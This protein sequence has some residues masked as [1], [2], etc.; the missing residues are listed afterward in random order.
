[1]YNG[2]LPLIQKTSPSACNSFNKK[3]S[4]YRYSIQTF[5]LSGL[6]I[7]PWRGGQSKYRVPFTLQDHQVKL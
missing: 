3:I 2:A 4:S 1:M 6:T 7:A 5:T